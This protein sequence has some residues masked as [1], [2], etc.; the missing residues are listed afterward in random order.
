[1]TLEV[2]DED[3]RQELSPETDQ[4]V[5]NTLESSYAPGN[6]PEVVGNITAVTPFFNMHRAVYLAHT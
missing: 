4:A 1:M 3:Q 6:C 2:L 5:R